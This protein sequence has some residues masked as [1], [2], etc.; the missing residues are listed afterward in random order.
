MILNAVLRFFSSVRVALWIILLLAIVSL[1]G[2]LL[3]QMPP[4]VA[5]DPELVQLWLEQVARPAYGGLTGVL[6]F[7]GLFDV[8]HSPVFLVLGSLLIV[9]ITVCSLKR[10]P[11]LIKISRGVDSE[12][13]LRLLDKGHATRATSRLSAGDGVAAIEN[14]FTKRS[15]RLRHLSS[16]EV[17]LFLADKNRL[18]PWGTYAIHLSL[19]LLIAGYLVGSYSGY[20]NDSFI[21]AEGET[22]DIG[23]PYGIS[24]HL[25]SF[26]DEYYATGAPKDYRAQVQLLSAGVVIKEGLIRVNYPME[27]G[28]LRIYQS[29]FGSAVRIGVANS[30]SG[31][32]VFNGSIALADGFAA[33]GYQRF[34]GTLDLNAQNLFV[35]LISP[36]AGGDPVIP[37][38]SIRLEFY[39]G[40]QPEGQ[41]IDFINIPIGQHAEFQGLVFSPEEMTQFSGFQLRE[42]PGLGL[43]WASLALFMLGLVLVFYFPHRQIIVS[44]KPDTKG[45]RISFTALGKKNQSAI[46][47][48]EAFGRAVAATGQIAPKTPGKENMN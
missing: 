4:V 42:D 19:I 30:S 20:S 44:I 6:D 43:V 28:G 26:E 45:S 3:R 11:S 21:V 23:A 16:G 25:E 35:Y 31:V 12:D 33:E 9:S 29:F 27:Y 2:T 46:E 5:A 17:K 40:E 48:M 34:S 38:D 15:Y 10:W 24:V 18:A 36:A 39:D 37:A 32:E 8:F 1:S 13:A 14:F 41:F 22:R 47:E 7:L